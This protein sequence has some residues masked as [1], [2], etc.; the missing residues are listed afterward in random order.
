M[1][2]R[3]LQFLPLL[4]LYLF[5]VIMLSSPS[6]EGDES[7]YVAYASRLTQEQVSPI[8]T[9]SLWCGPGYPIVLTPFAYFELPWLAAKLLNAVFVF[10]AILYFYGTLA[11]WL[12]DTHAFIFAWVLGLHPPLWRE[13]PAL[14]TESLVFLLMC[15]FLFHFTKSLS[16]QGAAALRRDEKNNA[17]D[18]PPKGQTPVRIGSKSSRASTHA[19]LHVLAASLFLGYLALTKILYGYAI[20]VGLL[21]FVALYFLRKQEKEKKTVCIYSLALI[22]C[23][24]YLMYTYSL[25]DKVFCW[26][27]SGGMSL[28]WI[29]TPNQDELGDWFSFADVQTNPDLAQHKPFF[30]EVA[31]LPQ[32]QRDSEFKKQAIF[33]ITHHPKKFL[34]NWTANIGRLLFSY[35]YSYSQQKLSTYFYLAPNMFLVVVFILSIGPAILRWNCIPFDIF[36][37]LLFALIAFGGSSLLSAYSR[38]FSPLAPILLLWIAFIYTRI[39]RIRLCPQPTV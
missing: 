6:F 13:M 24:P 22:W 26:G 25:T 18:L 19:W 3:I 9:V 32:V 38:Q 16:K 33:N 39:V 11:H 2:K 36:A 14:H 12:E 17:S 8:E 29:S 27:T 20:L 4:L 23:L 30:D 1:T 31:D 35:P 5:I 7:D 10:G 21:L 28:Y 34:A 37:L 15:G